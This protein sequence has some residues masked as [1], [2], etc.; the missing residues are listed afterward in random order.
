[1]TNFSNSTITST[2]GARSAS[3]SNSWLAVLSVALTATVFCA[4]EFMPVG[5]LRYVAEGLKVSEGTAGLMATVPGILAAFAAPLVTVAAVRADRRRVLLLL[6]ALLA[7]S[8]IIAMLAPNFAV[9]LFGRVLFGIGI[10]GFWA[11]GVGV[12]GRLVPAASVAKA[13]SIIFA[14]IS[15]GMLI[16]GP[17]GAFLGHVF[18]WRT[19]FGLSAFLSLVALFAQFATLPH[20]RVTERVKAR[21][22]LGIVATPSGR[23]GF[24]A[25]LF[26]LV[27]HYATYTYVTPILAQV[28]GF[29]DKAISSL[30]L[31]YTLIGMVG[32]FLG[33]AGGGWNVKLTLS[34]S[35]LLIMIPVAL[36]PLHGVTQATAIA[37]LAVWG[38]AYGA[39]PIAL[40][41]WM[42][43]AAPGIPEGGMALFVA[44]FQV[45]IALGSLFGGLVVDGLGLRS[46][47]Y[48]G[49]IVSLVA[50]L[51]LLA[52]S[53]RSM[54]G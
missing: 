14:G 48:F 50:L 31:G 29:H 53:P 10:G 42:M 7:A 47:M 52:F 32:N 5:L 30:L 20:L 23:V 13:T 17:V 2:F 27:G 37:L 1:M 12:G 28:F 15:L 33:G 18:G 51:I 41:M 54:K 16:G 19:A 39:M 44:N 36:L 25:M 45:S 4:S 9:L 22:L 3:P 11:I 21:D 26:V 35:T 46:A 40:Q 24:L 6:G 34:V 8:N 38:L 49:A 43:K